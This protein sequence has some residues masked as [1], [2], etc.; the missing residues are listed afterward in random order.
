MCSFSRF[1]SAL[2]WPFS[3]SSRMIYWNLMIQVKCSSSFGKSR[4]ADLISWRFI[5]LHS[6][7]WIHLVK[8]V[9]KQSGNS[10]DQCCRWDFDI[11][12]VVELYFF[13]D[14]LFALFFGRYYQ[15]LKIN[16]RYIV[17]RK[18]IEKN[19][20]KGYAWVIKLMIC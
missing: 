20:S 14:V 4:K 7:S 3:S 16:F 13:C 9:L 10:T 2:H 6:S 8:G 15:H 1:C 5:T 12:F 18:V 17:E 19:H 11:Y